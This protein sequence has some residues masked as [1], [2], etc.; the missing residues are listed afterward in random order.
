MKPSTFRRDPFTQCHLD[1]IDFFEYSTEMLCVA[2]KR[3]YFTR[4]NQAWTKTLGWSAVELTSRPYLDFVHPDDL[5]ATKR[6]ASLLLIDRHETVRFENRYRCRDGSY[7]WLAWK[8]ISEAGTANVIASARDV[9]EQKIQT[10]ALR[11]AEERFR[12]LANHAPVGIAQSDGDGSIFYVNDK[13]CELAGIHPDGALG[14]AWKSFIHPDDLDR[15]IDRWQ[16]AMH[17]GHDVPPHELRFLHSSGEVRWG[18]ASVAMLKDPKGEIVGQ[19]ATVADITELKQ[20]E[21]ALKS[22]QGLLRNL[23]EVQENEKQQLCCEF[24]DG[25]IQYAV[26]TTMSLEAYH[27][28]H[29]SSEGSEVIESAIRNLK[30]GI[31]DG[32]RT[33]QGIRPAEL[34][35]L[36]LEAAI[37]GLIEQF[38]GSG[39]MV[40]F[41]TGDPDLGRLPESVQ[42]T[43]Y[44]VTQEALNNARKYSGTDVI[45]IELRKRDGKLHLDIRD[46]GGGFDVTSARTRGFGLLGMVERVRL[47][48]GECIIESE[49]D[50]GTRISVCLPI[51]ADDP[52]DEL[53]S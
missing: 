29:L 9:T 40:T 21:E 4:V 30:K 20:T 12:T 16:K 45:R 24:H 17:A 53:A 43:L 19:I 42:T 37:H 39:I 6:E 10:E 50:V 23:I 1:M 46:F 36:N 25:L 26:G 2:D 34:D 38:S 15:E 31:V 32:R 49:P 41:T 22:R 5:E 47:L 18:S 8:A 3:G 44:R 27:R 11:K 35:D 52:D 48:G 7:R 14:F 33:I 28:N 51:S 13:W